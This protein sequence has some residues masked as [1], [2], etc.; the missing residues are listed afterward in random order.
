VKFLV[1]GPGM[2][3]TL[4]AAKLAKAGHEVS[5]LGRG[6]RLEE[7]RQSGL[8]IREVGADDVERIDVDVLEA[9]DDHAFDWI[10]VTVRGDQLPALL[11]A[12]SAHTATPNVM[13]LTNHAGE[14]DTWSE[15]V[16]PERLTLGFPG[17]TGYF[18]GDVLDYQI[19][20][21]A[22]QP[23]TFGELDGSRSP[24]LEQLAAALEGAGIP[25]AIESD[26]KAWLHYH[27]AWISALS[28][29]AAAANRSAE[30]IAADSSLR[31][32]AVD[33]IREG[34]D[35]LAALGY[36]KTPGALRLFT[37]LPRWLVARLLK[38]MVNDPNAKKMLE[39][40]TEGMRREGRHMAKQMKALSDAAG[41]PMPAYASLAT[42][43][44]DGSTAQ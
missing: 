20:P 30:R 44:D 23:T 12:I 29:M 11:N 3:G 28:L 43:L 41:I 16:G 25:A 34:F 1:F 18:D 42:H 2:I 22:F 7:I 8:R 36:R 14:L 37:W 21:R 40:P 19:A 39:Q 38:T 26:M 35:V 17:L 33:A 13:L 4:I 15:A 10:L 24:R 27:V 31:R 32:S 6:R 5:V 9:L